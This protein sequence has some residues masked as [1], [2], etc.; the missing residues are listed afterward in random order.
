MFVELFLK[1][2]VNSPW[3]FRCWDAFRDKTFWRLYYF[4]FNFHVKCVYL[5][6]V[7]AKITHININIALSLKVDLR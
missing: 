7:N 3:C 4:V 6:G 1:L 2:L 5:I